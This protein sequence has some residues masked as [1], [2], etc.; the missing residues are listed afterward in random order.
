MHYLSVSELKRTVTDWASGALPGTML[1]ITAKVKNLLELFVPS[2][3]L[4]FVVLSVQKNELQVNTVS[5]LHSLFEMQ[6][7]LAAVLPACGCLLVAQS[8]LALWQNRICCELQPVQY[9]VLQLMVEGHR[10]AAAVLSV[11][12]VLL[13]S[14]PGC[15]SKEPR[16]LFFPE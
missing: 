16:F 6:T 3:D 2:S 8:A 7:K 15:P 13:C 5:F 11:P 9:G 1:V 12:S 4:S 10:D 14:A